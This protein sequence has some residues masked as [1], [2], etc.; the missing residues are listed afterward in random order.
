MS[1]PKFVP[2]ALS[3]LNMMSARKKRI[4]AANPALPQDPISDMARTMHPEALTLTIESVRQENASVRTYRLKPAD[5]TLPYFLSGQYVSIKFKIGGTR[6]ARTYTF[7]SA[8]FESEGPDGYYELSIR[9]KPGGFVSSYIFDNW[10]PGTL[11]AAT[12]PHGDCVYSPLRDTRNIVA[13]AGGTGITPFRSMMKQIAECE[14]DLHLTLLYG[15]R[16]PDDD[17]FSEELGALCEKYPDRLKR[18]NTYEDTR[19]QDLRQGFLDADFIESCV[20]NAGEKTYFIC[21]PIAMYDFLRG[22]F[23]KLGVSERKQTRYEVCGIPEDVKRYPGF[24]A[25]AA[26]RT[27][28]LTVVTG[29]TETVIPALCAEPIL[30]AAER[31]GLVVS[32]RCRSGE[33]GICRSKLKSGDVFIVPD[34]DGRRAAD[35]ELGYIHPCSTYPLSDCVVVIPPGTPVPELN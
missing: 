9:R 5:G 16:D 4:K 14:P 25:D 30:Q 23:P 35:K 22:E 28:S 2:G 26:G 12:G 19:G 7:S 34:N 24:P 3:M 27:V 18:R 10:K 17:L 21:G 29:L 6:T 11:V 20:K 33:C 1:K 13:I 31:F 8:P 32:S 15:C